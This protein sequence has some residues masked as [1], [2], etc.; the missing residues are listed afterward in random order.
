VARLARDL[1]GHCELANAPNGGLRVRIA[2]PAILPLPGR[3]KPD[4]R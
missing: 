2:L 1:G 4:E 3:A